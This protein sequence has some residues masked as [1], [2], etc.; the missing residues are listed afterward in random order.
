M[1]EATLE[2]NSKRILI[3]FKKLTTISSNQTW[4]LQASALNEKGILKEGQKTIF[5]YFQSQINTHR[6]LGEVENQQSRVN[7]AL[8]P[9]AVNLILQR[10]ESIQTQINSLK[11]DGKLGA[12][13]GVNQRS[14]RLTTNSGPAFETTPSAYGKP[15]PISPRTVAAAKRDRSA[16][17]QAKAFR[18]R[19]GLIASRMPK[20]ALG[21]FP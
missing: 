14:N 17:L 5:E 7:N 11:M 15:R 16:S 9:D 13:M 20:A 3:D 18:R 10:L 2:K 4:N 12:R 1:G 19:R 8:P 6:S 21:N